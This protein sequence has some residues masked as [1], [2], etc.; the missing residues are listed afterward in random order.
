MKTSITIA[1]PQITS[2]GPRCFS[3][4]STIPAMLRA[5]TTSTSRLSFR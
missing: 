2:S 1:A 4:G 5:P 3:G